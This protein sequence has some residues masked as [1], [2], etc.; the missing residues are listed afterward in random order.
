MVV[1]EWL[2]G[3]E[4]AGLDDEADSVPKKTWLHVAAVSKP[5]KIAFYIGKKKIEFEKK[6]ESAQPFSLTLNPAKGEFNVD[7]L[8]L[9]ETAAVQFEAFRE[10]TEN[11]VPYAALDHREKW[12]VLEAQDPEKVKTNLFETEQFRAAVRAVIDSDTQGV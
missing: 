5:G 11:R 7:E 10:N 6:S 4:T 3:I 8:L 1:H 12:L 9:D 2:D